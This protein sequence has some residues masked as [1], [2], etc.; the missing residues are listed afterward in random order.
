LKP[1][2]SCCIRF[3]I[4]WLQWYLGD[5]YAA[6]EV[7]VYD[8]HP[9]HIDA[10]F[11]PLDPGK[12]LINPERV[13]KVPEIF[14]ESEWGILVCSEPVMPESHLVYN[15]SRWISMNVLMLDEE[16]VIV[17]KGEEP[18]IKALKD[19]GF[20]PIPC[21][22]WYFETIGGVFKALH[23]ISGEEE[24]SSLFLNPIGSSSPGY[25]CS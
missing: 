14:V 3:G 15:K 7:E 18:L 21:I 13:K 11:Y 19:W 22:F 24:I 16:R 5:D 25:F 6:H 10:T 17:S 4:D 20:K 9:M 2:S 8:T 1:K 12:L 23:L